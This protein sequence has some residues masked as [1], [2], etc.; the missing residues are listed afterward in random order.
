VGQSL[1]LLLADLP[2]Q[3]AHLAGTYGVRSVLPEPPD[4]AFV[5]AFLA[6]GS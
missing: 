6:K 1:V 2:A 5:R 3:L 4:G